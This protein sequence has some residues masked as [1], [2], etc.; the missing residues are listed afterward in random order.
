MTDAYSSSSDSEDP[1]YENFI[2]ETA[3]I[4]RLYEDGVPQQLKEAAESEEAEVLIEGLEDTEI[5][6]PTN[7][8]DVL[9]GTEPGTKCV[10]ERLGIQYRTIELL[11][12]YTSLMVM[13]YIEERH[14]V[15]KELV[16]GLRYAVASVDTIQDSLT[17]S[18][19]IWER[20]QSFKLL[21]T[22]IESRKNLPPVTKIVCLAFGTILPRSIDH[23]D[24]KSE[25]K[26]AL[27]LSLRDVMNKRQRDTTGEIKCYAQDPA[28][29][30]IDK[31]I[32]ENYGITIL[33]DPA[34]FA[35]IDESTIV[36]TFAPGVPVRQ[37]VADIA[38]PA[39][40][41]WNTSEKVVSMKDGREKF[42]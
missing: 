6:I 23:W 42:L 1:L 40:M 32:L 24:H 29:T 7:T 28:Y 38:R 33:E 8:N 15:T 3:G 13:Y 34:A 4:R 26:Y 31:S 5:I 36:L 25:F 35:Q 16:P 20:S 37:L 21:Q 18:I 9:S 39:M 12:S 14:K 11:T 19:Q 30:E 41:I 2:R 22:I 10:V 17:S 27:A